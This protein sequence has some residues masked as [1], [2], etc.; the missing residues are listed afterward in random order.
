MGIRRIFSRAVWKKC[1]LLEVAKKIF[2]GGKG[3]EISSF[4][5]EAKKTTFLSKM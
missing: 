1:T 4:P 3:G 5:L 2:S